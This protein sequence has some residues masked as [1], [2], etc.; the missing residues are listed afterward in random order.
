MLKLFEPGLIPGAQ[1]A[2]AARGV[3]SEDYPPGG[4]HWGFQLQFDLAHEGTYQHDQVLTAT[5]VQEIKAR[6]VEVWSWPYHDGP[7]PNDVGDVATPF[8]I[9]G[10]GTSADPYKMN[11]SSFLLTEE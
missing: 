3:E 6:Y 9:I 5:Q 1:W 10:S 8:F 11:Y 7:M 4:V 2:Y